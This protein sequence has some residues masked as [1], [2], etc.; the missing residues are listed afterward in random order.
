MNHLVGAQNVSIQRFRVAGSLRRI[1]ML[2]RAQRFVE[3]VHLH[4][5]DGVILSFYTTEAKFFVKRNAVQ[6]GLLI[7]FAAGM[8]DHFHLGI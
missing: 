4:A 2:R 6:P 7:F 8:L 3:Q 1:R 5:V